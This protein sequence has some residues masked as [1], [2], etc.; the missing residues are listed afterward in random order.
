MNIFP[1]ND[2]VS[3]KICSHS[4][5]STKKYDVC[6]KHIRRILLFQDVFIL[7]VIRESDLLSIPLRGVLQLVS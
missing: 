2:I 3:H 4:E 1:Y 6:K 7:I 5:Q